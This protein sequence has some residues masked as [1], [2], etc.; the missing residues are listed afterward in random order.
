MHSLLE[1]L[2]P[3]DWILPCMNPSSFGYAES[4]RKFSKKAARGAIGSAIIVKRLMV[5]AHNRQP[6]AT[7]CTVIP[8]R[9]SG[10]LTLISDN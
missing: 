7:N 3:S 4:N 8:L 1:A 6:Q 10:R 5:P 2:R 9:Q